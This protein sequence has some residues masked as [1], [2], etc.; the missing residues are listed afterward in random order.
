MEKI[1]LKLSIILNLKRQTSGR[2]FGPVIQSFDGMFN[3]ALIIKY[4]LLL[5]LLRPHL[6]KRAVQD[7]I[8]CFKT[9]QL[10]Q[11]REYCLN[12]HLGSLYMKNI[13]LN[14]FLT[15]GFSVANHRFSFF[16]LLGKSYCLIEAETTNEYQFTLNRT[17]PF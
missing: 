7:Y 5:I 10:S 11:S 15:L 14:I 13:T 6:P 1:S 9:L 4:E 8:S 3:R 12:C 16:Q 2:H 17:H